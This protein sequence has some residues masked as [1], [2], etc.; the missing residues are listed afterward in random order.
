MKY[1]YSIITLV[2][3]AVGF[4]ASEESEESEESKVETSN[5]CGTYII[6]DENNVTFSIKVNDDMTVVA[7][8]NGQKYYG[9]WSNIVDR[10]RFK[11]SG[12][13]DERP[14]IIFKE[15]NLRIDNDYEIADDGF[16]YGDAGGRGRSR[17]R[18]PQFR[19][20]YRK[21]N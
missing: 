18:D 1:L 12:D 8:G 3:F 19:L 17:N 16:I 21:T 2:L 13:A 20:K 15:G 10:V 9:S 5:L 14:S 6:T 4:A 11:F 7:E